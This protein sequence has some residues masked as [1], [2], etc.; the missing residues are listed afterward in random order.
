MT[1]ERPVE[2]QPDAADVPPRCPD[3]GTE[4]VRG[5]THPWVSRCLCEYRHL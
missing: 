4:F 3:C 1:I 5:A 2:R